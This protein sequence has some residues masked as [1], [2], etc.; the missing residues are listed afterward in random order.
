MADDLLGWQNTRWGM[1]EEEIIEHMPDAPFQPVPHQDFGTAYCKLILSRVKIGDSAFEVLMQMNKDTD[2]LSHV[3]IK[4]DGDPS[5]AA[6]KTV[7]ND[8]LRILT[9]RFGKPAR[10]A[11]S[12]AYNWT[13]PTTTVELFTIEIKDILCRI[14]VSFRP[15]E[16]WTPEIP[17]F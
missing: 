3:L 8:T 13:H 7:F 11:T 17:A 9:E 10:T 15:T 2:R 16:N 1:T 12:N 5:Y 14:A 6:D 4:N